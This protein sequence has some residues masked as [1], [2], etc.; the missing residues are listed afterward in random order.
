MSVA[1]HGMAIARADQIEDHRQARG[2]PSHIEP[3]ARHRRRAF[4]QLVENLAAL[5]QDQRVIRQ[6][7]QADRAG[8]LRQ[9]SC[10]LQIPADDPR[11]SDIKCKEIDIHQSFKNRL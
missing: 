4:H 11:R 8:P 10:R 6:L 7:G 3:H 2:F 1:I 9:T 5:G